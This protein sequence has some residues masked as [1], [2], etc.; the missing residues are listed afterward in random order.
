MLQ[1]LTDV[2]G[3]IGTADGAVTAYNQLQ[4]ELNLTNAEMD[5]LVAQKLAE[6]LE[7]DG[8]AAAAAADEIET[9][10]D[11]VL[12]AR[13]AA[14]EYGR[15]VSSAEWGR[16]GIDGA[17]AAYEEYRQLVTGDRQRVSGLARGVGRFGRVDRARPANPCLICRP[18]RVVPCSTPWTSWGRRS[19][20]IWR[21]HSMTRT[22]TSTS[23]AGRW[24]PSP[25]KP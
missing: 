6:K 24:T 9:Y 7:A 15:T 12:S 25:N 19:S 20:R 5:E 13:D 3:I 1:R 8:E 14:K 23:S 16:A 11:A 10:R 2:D 22:G 4:T 18:L 21:R 17:T